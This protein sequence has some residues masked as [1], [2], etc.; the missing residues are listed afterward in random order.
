ME[1]FKML[2]GRAIL[3]DVPEKKE[4]SIQLSAQ[5]EDYIMKEAMKLWTA[6]NVYA[7]GT[8]VEDVKE[9]DKVYV[10]TGALESS[11]KIEVDGKIKLVITEGDVIIVW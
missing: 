5:D 8:T 10:R 9:G 4:S 3:I 2:R 1:K 6:L 7:V 11:E